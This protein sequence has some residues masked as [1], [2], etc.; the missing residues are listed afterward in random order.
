MFYQAIENI[1]LKINCGSNENTYLLAILRWLIIIIE[2][3]IIDE[4][5]NQNKMMIN[6]TPLE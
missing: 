4:T 5:K 1:V 6:F 3:K 2:I